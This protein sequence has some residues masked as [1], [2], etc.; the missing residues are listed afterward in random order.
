MKA[1]CL[2]VTFASMVGLMAHTAGAA[3]GTI[4]FTG[5][6]TADT[7][8]VDTASQNYTVNMGQV[9]K[10]NF[11]AV[12]TPGAQTSFQLTLSACPP[13]VTGVKFMAT[14]GQINTTNTD[15]L[16]LDR[17]STATG[18]GIALY[19]S[20]GTQIPYRTASTQVYP[21]TDGAATINLSAALVSTSDTVTSGD[22]TAT[23]PFY[24]TYQ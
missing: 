1:T 13:S 22:Y 20:N 19:D 16:A 7:C 9:A 14:S 17:S 2:A 5:A 24:I 10:T 12:G 15:L 11:T 8:T 18:F 3:D 21:V 4:H 23:T 6:L